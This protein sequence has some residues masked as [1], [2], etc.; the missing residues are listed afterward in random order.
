MKLLTQS[1]G[2]SLMELVVAISLSTMIGMV[3]FMSARSGDDQINSRDIRMAIQE[4]AREGLYKMVQEIR[5]SAPSRITI[6]TGGTSGTSLTIQVPDPA[7]LVNADYTL[8][9]NSAHSIQYSL[10]NGQLIRTDQTTNK[11]AVLSNDVTAVSFTGDA[12]QPNRVTVALDVQKQ[13]T[14]GRL[15]PPTALRMTAQAEVRNT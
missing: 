1:S 10:S 2:F 8:N 9:W 15:M 6:G 7:S 13:L 4:S 11:T 14:N 3:I 12:A 5:Q